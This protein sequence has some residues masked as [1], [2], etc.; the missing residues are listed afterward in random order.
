MKDQNSA[1]E[2]FE[3]IYW[4]IRSVVRAATAE[5]LEY[6]FKPAELMDAINDGFESACKARIEKLE[7]EIAGH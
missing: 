5:G 7:R 6:G 3:A 2:A 4:T 1:G